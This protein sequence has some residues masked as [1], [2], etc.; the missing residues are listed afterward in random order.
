MDKCSAI[1]KIDGKR[2]SRDSIIDGLCRQ[3][4]KLS[5]ISIETPTVIL[6]SNNYGEYQE[7][8]GPKHSVNGSPY[9]NDKV[10][11]FL[12]KKEGVNEFFKYCLDCRQYNRKISN[13][14][15]MKH[16]YNAE[17]HSQVNTSTRYCTFKDHD[18]IN[19]IYKRDKV[20]IELFRK[21]PDDP[22]SKSYDTCNSCR[23][24]RANYNREHIQYKKDEAET[25]GNFFCTNCHHIKEHSERAINLD[26]T[27]SILCI[28]CKEIEKARSL[29]IRTWYNE[30]KL[31]F[32]NKFCVSCQ[33]CRCI[34]LRP[35]DDGYITIKLETYEKGGAIYV[36]YNSIEYV[37]SD[38]LTMF[39]DF[40]ELRIIQFDHLPENKQ[41]AR[42]LLLPEHPYIPK[43]RNVS[44]M[45]SKNAIQLEALKCQHLCGK[46]H[47]EETIDREIGTPYNSK[48]LLE[49]QKLEYINSIKV[50]NKGC[51]ICKYWDPNLIRFFELDHI[52]PKLKI[53]HISR[54]IKDNKYSIDDLIIEAN[55]CRVLCQHC[56]RIHT[57]KQR[58]IK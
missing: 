57:D 21:D 42:R 31:D 44:K 53:E 30:V 38:F 15:M 4:A 22:R 14:I 16:K 9:R 3:H 58:A 24:Y 2:C 6:L 35:P 41:R 23:A 25:L 36:N 43:I 10:P 1:T 34:F 17:V 19:L 11:K 45:S 56:H 12:F 28:D 29:D 54:M 8:A 32:I 33:K 39:R 52:D 51:S 48:S 47:I 13:N 7:C 26:G 40:L 49:R 18:S 20:P 50:N 27:D 55:K 46:C 37:V 5:G